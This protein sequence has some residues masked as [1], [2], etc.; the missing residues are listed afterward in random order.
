MYYYKLKRDC[1]DHFTGH[2]FV[3]NELLTEHERNTKARYISDT[4]FDVFYWKRTNTFI[5]FGVRFQCSAI[6]HT[7]LEESFI[8]EYNHSIYTT[9]NQCYASASTAKQRAESHCLE[10]CA[11]V[12]GYGFKILSYNTWTFTCAY[13]YINSRTG[14]EHM[15]VHTGYNVYDFPLRTA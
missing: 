8:Y 13:K 9:I 10:C 15:I 11:L 4:L 7:K 1:F 3:K 12:E 6:E 5:N 14:Y 2:A